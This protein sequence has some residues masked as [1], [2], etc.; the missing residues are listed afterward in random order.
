MDIYTIPLFSKGDFMKQ[1]LFLFYFCFILLVFY[2]RS[3]YDVI[4]D[5]GEIKT[6][7]DIVFQ[8]SSAASKSDGNALAYYI[9]SIVSG[10]DGSKQKNIAL[11][12]WSQMVY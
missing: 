9:D 4:F 2:G 6:K 5:K 1:Y 10:K 7:V 8:Y 3:E 12:A 11:Q